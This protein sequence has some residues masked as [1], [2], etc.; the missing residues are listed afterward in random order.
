[1]GG[2]KKKIVKKVFIRK[3]PSSSFDLLLPHNIISG[4]AGAVHAQVTQRRRAGDGDAEENSSE[5]FFFF[6]YSPVLYTCASFDIAGA[7]N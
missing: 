4:R 5:I 6:F 3:I 2:S 7:A 1:M